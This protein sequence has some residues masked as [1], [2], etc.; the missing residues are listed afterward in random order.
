MNI[1]VGQNCPS[2][3]VLLCTVH[4]TAQTRIV[5]GYPQTARS[6]FAEPRDDMS[7]HTLKP[8][9]HVVQV[10]NTI[11]ES[12]QPEAALVVTLNGVD[13]LWRVPKC[14]LP[15]LHVVGYQALVAANEDVALIVFKEFVDMMPHPITYRT[16][17]LL[18]CFV[19]GHQHQ[20]LL[21]STY[22]QPSVVSLQPVTTSCLMALHSLQ[23][24]KTLCPG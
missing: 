12:A 9:Q 10:A 23:P 11:I 24:A 17:N 7:R 3:V 13:K 1:L 18:G 8:V 15:G 5:A 22:P 19:V 4:D 14:R 6:I 21:P 2:W 16:Q 20:A